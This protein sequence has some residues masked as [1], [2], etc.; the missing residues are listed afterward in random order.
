MLV[1]DVSA[2]IF[3]CLAYPL[4]SNAFMAGVAF[5]VRRHPLRSASNCMTRG[6]GGY[7]A[8]WQLGRPRLRIRDST[9]MA[10]AYG[11]SSQRHARANGSIASHGPAQM[12]WLRGKIVEWL[13]VMAEPR[14]GMRSCRHHLVK[15][16]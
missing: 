9:V 10:T 7:V 6:W 5:L 1:E 11:L 16:D 14:F 3:R 8:G 13:D 4:F 2:A 12:L 15:T